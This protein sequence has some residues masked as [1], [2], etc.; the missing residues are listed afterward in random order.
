MTCS[1]GFRAPARGGELAA[2]TAAALAD[3]LL[4]KALTAWLRL[5]QRRLVLLA[6]G[7]DE[8]PRLHPRF[9]A[10]RRDWAH[11]VEAFAPAEPGIE[12]PSWLVDDG[13]VVLELRDAERF[14]GH[15]VCDARAARRIRDETDAL[16]QR[17]EAGFAPTVLG[18]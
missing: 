6:A 4:S 14:C 17:C 15:A 5:P 1:V 12:V 11:A 8:F 13:P 2:R 3:E 7:Y 9:V 16:L 10:W 18:L